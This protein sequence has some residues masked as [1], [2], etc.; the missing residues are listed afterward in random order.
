MTWPQTGRPWTPPSPGLRSWQAALAYPGT[1]LFEGTS[2]SVGGGTGRSYRILCAPWLGRRDLAARVTKLGIPASP[3]SV[4]PRPVRSAREPKFRGR[5]CRGAL[6][7]PRDDRLV[8]GYSAGLGLLLHIRRKRPFRW[9]DG[10]EITD[11]ILGTPAFRRRV[12]AG[13]SLERILAA[14]APAV[15]AWREKRAA[16]LLYD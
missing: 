10:G 16:S 1:A 2:A 12:D 3:V 7:H 9:L 8:N 5:R 13:W 4:V 6:L 15:R 11:A 14:E